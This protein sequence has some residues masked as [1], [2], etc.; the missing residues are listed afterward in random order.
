MTRPKEWKRESR[1]ARVTAEKEEVDDGDIGGR[2]TEI[3][4]APKTAVKKRGEKLWIL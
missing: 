4:P 3:R 2:S 1:R